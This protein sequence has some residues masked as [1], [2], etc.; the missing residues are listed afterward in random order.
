MDFLQRILEPTRYGISDS[1]GRL[2]RPTVF[3]IWS[4][5]FY[6][7]NIFRD[8]KNWL[9]LFSWVVTCSLVVPFFIFFRYFF[10]LDLL[11][12]GFIYSTIGVPFMLNVLRDY[13][14]YRS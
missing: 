8:R 3:Q 7:L 13:L 9:P 10:S 14:T 4:E 11:L 1:S 12:L 6:R 5:F 2:I